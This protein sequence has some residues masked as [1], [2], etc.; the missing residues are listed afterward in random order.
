VE[1]LA[2]LTPLFPSPHLSR[3][4]HSRKIHPDKQGIKRVGAIGAVFQ[5]VSSFSVRFPEMFFMNPED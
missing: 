1:F 3:F 4:L 5:P 2:N